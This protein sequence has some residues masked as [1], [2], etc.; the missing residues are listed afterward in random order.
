[1]KLRNKL[2]SL[3]LAVLLL[4]PVLLSLG[5]LRAVAAEASPSEIETYVSQQKYFTYDQYDILKAYYDLC[6]EKGYTTSDVASLERLKGAVEALAGGAD[7]YDDF[8]NLGEYTMATQTI[9]NVGTFGV[10]PANPGDFFETT[11][12][13]TNY[14]I[15][16]GG[17][18]SQKYLSTDAEAASVTWNK[19]WPAALT[20]LSSMMVFHFENWYYEGM[21]PSQRETCGYA[22]NNAIQR[23]QTQISHMTNWLTLKPELV[24]GD[25]LS[26]FNVVANYLTGTRIVYNY[27]DA[28]NFCYVEHSGGNPGLHKVEVVDGVATTTTVIQWNYLLYTA[29]FANLPD[30]GNVRQNSNVSFEFVWNDSKECYTITL[31]SKNDSSI[32][33]SADLTAG[34]LPVSKMDTIMVSALPTGNSARSLLSYVKSV[35]YASSLVR[36]VITRIDKEVP[37]LA[38]VKRTDIAELEALYAE[39]QEMPKDVQDQLTN[40]KKLTDAIAE[41]KRLQAA[42]E[43]SFSVDDVLTFE[44]DE[45]VWSDFFK[46]TTASSVVANPSVDAMNGS[47]KVLMA[48]GQNVNKSMFFVD[49]LEDD[50][51]SVSYKLYGTVTFYTSYQDGNNYQQF[52]FSSVPKGSTTG[53]WQYGGKKA[54]TNLSGDY[55]VDDFGMPEGVTAASG[56]MDVFYVIKGSTIT[57]EFAILG[58][59]GNYYYRNVSMSRSNALDDVNCFGFYGNKFYIDDLKVVKGDSDTQYEIA[60]FLKT[61]KDILAMRP[62][63]TF[64]SVTDEEAYNNL[65][66]GYE[67]LTEEAKV[68]LGGA[69]AKMVS[70][71]KAAWAALD[72]T[73]AEQDQKAKDNA[74]NNYV[75]YAGG[76]K[77]KLKY[78]LFTG[79]DNDDSLGQFYVAYRKW[80]YAS[81]VYNETL[82]RNVLRLSD[83][84]TIV[85]KDQFV[86]E[87]ATLASLSYHIYPKNGEFVVTLSGDNRLSV[88][89]GNLSLYLYY[90]NSSN[91]VRLDFNTA[92]VYIYTTKGGTT[93]RTYTAYDEE[94]SFDPS[95]GLDVSIVYYNN[96]ATMT[97]TDAEGN[98]FEYEASFSSTAK[99]LIAFYCAAHGGYRSYNLVSPHT[100][101]IMEF[102]VDISNITAQFTAGDWDDDV[103]QEELRVSY[104]GNTYISPDDVAVIR[105]ENLGALVSSVKVI[106]LDDKTTTTPGFIDRTAYD[107]DGVHDGE[108]T[109]SPVTP[110]IDWSKAV[111]VTCIHKSTDSIQFIVP[112]E[113]A[114][115]TDWEHGI[116]AVQLS[117]VINR[118][119]QTK[120][121]YLN[122][123]VIDFLLGSDGDIASPG[124]ELEIV[125]ENISP[126]QNANVNATAY[127]KRIDD[128]DIDDVK[129]MLIS[130]DD[131]SVRY[132]LQIKEIT[133]DYNIVAI[134]P[135]NIPVASDG[136]TTEWE[137]YVYN[138]YGDG[139]CWSIPETI[140]IGRPLEDLRPLNY[141]NILNYNDGEAFTYHI[142][143]TPIIQSALNR[144]QELGGGTLYLPEG[145][146][147][148]E[149]TVYVPDNVRLQ[150]DGMELTNILGTYFSQNYGNLD[151][152]TGIVIGNNC[153]VDGIA[154]YM[155]RANKV[156]STAGYTVE[157]VTLNDIKFYTNYTAWSN[158]GL[159]AGSPLA[160]REE[161][162]NYKENGQGSGFIDGTFVNVKVTNILADVNHNGLSLSTCYNSGN[163]YGRFENIKYVC[164]TDESWN[165]FLCNSAVWKNCQ[166]AGGNATQARGVY[167]YNIQWGPT[168]GYNREIWVA[169]LAGN[170]GITFQVLPGEDGTLENSTRLRLLVGG[171][172]WSLD[173]Q[174]YLANYHWQIYVRTGNGAGQ[175]REIVGVDKA[176]GWILIDRPFD[177]LI[178]RNSQLTVRQPREDMYFVDCSFYEGGCPGG[179]FGGCADVVHDGTYFDY[180]RNCYM[181]AIFGD[182]NWYVS[183]VNNTWTNTP[184]IMVANYGMNK[185]SSYA[186]IVDNTSGVNS[187]LGFLFRN[188][189]VVSMPM[190]ASFYSAESQHDFIVDNNRFNNMNYIYEFTKVGGTDGLTFYRNTGDKLIGYASNMITGT[191]SLGYAYWHAIGD[192][193]EGIS[194]VVGDVNQ[195]GSITLKDVTT[196]HYAI[197]GQITLTDDQIARGDVNGD[198]QI[199]V[200]DAS[201]IRNWLVGK[202]DTFPA[203][204]EDP[205][206]GDDG[207]TPTETVE[208]LQPSVGGNTDDSGY[209]PGYH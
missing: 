41:A 1:M 97:V 9:E 129:V 50:Y 205:G 44:S 166:I 28:N 112:E 98:A 113:G 162:F 66:E 78:R 143:A 179:F 69:Y 68:A 81:V 62:Y 194:F 52:Q 130:R 182:V 17:L 71:I 115:G 201:Y 106:R 120:I 13:T 186:S 64:L 84:M 156:I 79:T 163:M 128:R 153:T 209:S 165:R 15:R 172:V 191:N 138:G 149:H 72:T 54:G 173:G 200:V 108:F 6:V 87:K 83:D 110:N 121:V 145:I 105:G 36:Y 164:G 184:Y 181:E 193:L 38:D 59:D 111:T 19:T 23:G 141:I 116:F 33:A 171:T 144:L 202:I 46:D 55:G 31:V 137:V 132:N 63:T 11:T 86:P 155:K 124:T 26:I 195:D 80:G 174:E 35:S 168:S 20:S 29:G 148:L 22:S 119:V 12:N 25:E 147:R 152:Y 60:D 170:T 203:S 94:S 133:S 159:G 199:T 56:W 135:S 45:Y 127:D 207:E 125:G 10:E 53:S 75:I 48:G 131:P 90:A 103:V 2:I 91:Y 32:R 208:S 43:D 85:M 126:N 161:L 24:E 76:D 175:T 42:Y 185:G 77:Y 107:Y 198:G 197:A 118:Q 21:V 176:N 183:H 192:T 95:G 7:F 190:Y 93:S 151:N 3:V 100:G 206:T 99:N 140:K 18:S 49:K 47:D 142:N 73:A 109:L 180:T 67:I 8:K 187:Q 96:K 37:E 88:H 167:M 89:S 189:D 122:A 169:D 158:N 177:V 30:A 150:G 14:E 27:I 146:Y 154:F 139:T 74:D 51:Y 65:V 70:D 40:I 134:I 34:T 157:N 61:N 123:P 104:S 102:Y 82:D 92:G 5:Q 4:A 188:N 178:N 101:E 160:E 196:L 16:W 57:W 39:I 114:D 117:A 58:S 204:P 136:S